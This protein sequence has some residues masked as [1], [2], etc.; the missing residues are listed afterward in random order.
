[1]NRFIAITVMFALL[2]ISLLP[3]SAGANSVVGSLHDLTSG[4]EGRVCIFC[5]T[6]H[7]AIVLQDSQYTGPLWN[8]DENSVLVNPDYYTSYVSSTIVASKG[9]SVGQP[10]GASRLC[11]SCHDGTIALASASHG[12]GVSLGTLTGRTLLGTNLSTDHPVSILYGQ[13]TGEYV[14]AATVTGTTRVKLPKHGGLP[15]VECTSCHDPHDNQYSNFMVVNT[16]IQADALCTVCHAPTSW[17]GS[18]HQVTTSLLAKGC[19]SCHVPHKAQQG[20][21]LLKLG[22]AGGIDSNCTAFCHN[23]TAG[24]SIGSFTHG[25]S[26]DPT[27]IKHKGA[28]NEAITAEWGV[29]TLPLAQANKHVHCVDCHNPH[30]AM[31]SPVTPPTPPA[32]DGVLK[33]VRGVDIGGQ[34]RIGG[35]P[36]AQYEY[37]VCFRC[38]SGTD[39][40]SGFFNNAVMPII[41]IFNSWNEKERFNPGS[42]ISW[43]PVAARFTRVGS[44]Q[45]LSLRDPG[46]TT[47][48]CNDCHDPHGSVNP[49]L[50]RN[51][52]PDGFAVGLNT[53]NN[54]CYICHD[55]NY[56]I[57][58]SSNVMV[59]RLHKAHVM[60]IHQ[61]GNT[62]RA[63]CSACHDP[64]GVPNK[65]G[66]T[67]S[68]NAVHL[69]NFDSRFANPAT[70]SYD[71][72]A[73]SCFIGTVSGLTQQCHPTTNP[74]TLS[75]YTTYS[76]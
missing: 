41:R 35:T 31:T 28:E 25:N 52:S 16:A 49:H 66:L 68:N 56:L 51:D 48:Y 54:L 10:Q 45:G 43:H 69:M 39:A 3:G 40:E 19:T 17:A 4:T 72:T 46:M 42:A 65:P 58:T 50:L 44:S 11:L 2:A 63:G 55:D 26:S 29:D 61:S 18:A 37:E 47:I 34:P 15:Y 14:D 27:G 62:Y 24:R 23:G 21:S 70:S 73:G 9:K 57:N 30:Q 32:V 12:I 20:E 6:P 13:K 22:G 75:F 76:P 60:G 59:R 53:Y 33:G 38:H 74:G 1:M 5:H 71:A 8:R 7:H 36:Y 67:N 64:H